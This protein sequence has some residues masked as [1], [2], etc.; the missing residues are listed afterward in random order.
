MNDDKN[1]FVDANRLVE[2]AKEKHADVA[3]DTPVHI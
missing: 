1:V 2:I 3:V